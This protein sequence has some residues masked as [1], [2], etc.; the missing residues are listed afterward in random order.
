MPM[1]K[2]IYTTRCIHYYQ[3]RL[4][5]F[6]SGI[7]QLVQYVNVRILSIMCVYSVFIIVRESILFVISSTE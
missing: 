4:S 3:L 5:K 2:W 7:N 6:G 1:W